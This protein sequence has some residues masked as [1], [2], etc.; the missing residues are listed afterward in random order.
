MYFVV[1]GSNGDVWRCNGRLNMETGQRCCNGTMKAATT[2]SF[3]YNRSIGNKK[4][5]QILYFWLYRLR[6]GEIAEMLRL[7][8]K[9]VAKILQDWF[10]VMHEDLSWG[11]VKIGKRYHHFIR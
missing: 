1:A 11:D 2:D 7:N 9:T 8:P 10:E 4:I 6:R 3:F 5:L